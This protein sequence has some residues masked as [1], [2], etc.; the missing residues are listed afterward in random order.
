MFVLALLVAACGGTS[1]RGA[2][3]PSSAPISI[4]PSA[5]PAASNPAT[6]AQ[7]TL[8]A[9]YAA[10]YHD[11][12]TAVRAGKVD[13]PALGQHAVDGALDQL[14]Q[15]VEQY[16]NLGVLP[17][18]VPVLHAHVTSVDLD[19]NPAQAVVAS[20]PSAPR[21]V[22][23]KTGQPVTFKALPANPVTVDLETVQGQWVVSLFTVDRSRSCSG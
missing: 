15:G 18:G 11:V 9:A 10:T 16:L 23:R 14:R 1:T 5:S 3:E 2:P 12:E 8:L 17:V 4:S 7:T 19:T 21:L 20:C 13:S 22:N 6:A